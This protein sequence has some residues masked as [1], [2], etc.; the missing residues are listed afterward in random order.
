MA[1]NEVIIESQEV[2]LQDATMAEFKKAR[3][4]GKET[5][6]R[7]TVKEEKTE[8]EEKPRVRGGFQ[9]KID[10]LVKAQAA[11]EEG[12]A[13]AEKRATELEAKLNGDGKQKESDEPKRESFQ[14]EAEYI[15]ALTRWEVKQEMRVEKEN[16]QRQAQESVIKEAVNRYNSGMIKLQAEN[17]DY[18]ELMQQ[19]IKVPSSI[20]APIKLEMDN[21][22]EV[23]I[24]LAQNP[25]ICEELMKMKPSQA[26]AAVWKIS[27]KLAG[28]ANDDE[29]E[30]D[31]AEREAL[32]LAEKEKA[33][34]K[35]E[36][37]KLRPIRT[38]TSGSTT[39]STIPLDKTDFN[40][41]KKLRAQ[42]RVQ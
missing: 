1:E 28:G 42:G 40:A 17:E 39:R 23:T 22:P 4:D 26:V 13:A 2:P 8:A 5:A 11:L 6:T 31:K 36:K 20:E 3:A 21:G 18:K 27:E 35:E 34:A 14:T 12:K 41:Y 29:T 38:V 16:E 37:P 10:R 9:A 15:R 25:E 7:E 19:D 32:E 24:F 30:D 33:A